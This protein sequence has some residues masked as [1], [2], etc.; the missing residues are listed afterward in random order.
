MRRIHKNQLHFVDRVEL[1]RRSRAVSTKSEAEI[2]W[3]K[4]RRSSKSNPIIA[5][6]QNS[7]GPRQ[8]CVYCCDS[9]SADVDHFIPVAKNYRLTFT[10]SN[11]L[12]VCPECNRRKNA[13]FPVNAAGE[14]LVLNPE[15]VDPWNHFILDTANGLIGPRYLESDFD[16]IGEA[17]LEILECINYEAVTEGRKRVIR[18]YHEALDHVLSSKCA[19]Q[20]MRAVAREINEDDFGLSAWF[21]LHEGAE[22]EPFLEFKKRLPRQWRAFLRLSA[23]HI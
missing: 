4:F 14:P 17:T 6:L 10:W 18:R 3:K 1:L 16:A 15:A 20:A 19:E 8:R 11:L 12:W 13:K 22:E 5:A 23:K 7:V 21:A 2:E 9:R